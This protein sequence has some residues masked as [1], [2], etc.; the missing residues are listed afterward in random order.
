LPPRTTGLAA[1]HSADLLEEIR[2]L[3]ARVANV[4]ERAEGVLW[5][6]NAGR[7]PDRHYDD[8]QETTGCGSDCACACP[9]AIDI[10][11]TASHWNIAPT[12]KSPLIDLAPSSQE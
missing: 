7:I 6:V 11:A 3:R 12:R 5:A 1:V 2:Q 10:P 4:L 8:K 9:N